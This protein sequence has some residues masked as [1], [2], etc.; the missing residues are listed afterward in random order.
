M[1]HLNNAIRQCFRVG[2]GD[3]PTIDDATPKD[4]EKLR[5]AA[6]LEDPDTIHEAFAER[7]LLAFNMAMAAL[8]ETGALMPLDALRRDLLVNGTSSVDDQ[9]N[10][11]LERAWALAAD[12]RKYDEPPNFDELRE[13]WWG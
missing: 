1:N 10:D 7:D 6:L 8:V 13:A 11:G 4:R 12:D 9:V 5:Q 2:K 3:C